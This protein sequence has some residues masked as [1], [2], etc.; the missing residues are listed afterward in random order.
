MRSNIHLV[1]GVHLLQIAFSCLFF[2]HFSIGVVIFFSPIC[3]SGFLLFFLNKVYNDFL[4]SHGI[5]MF[6]PFI[7]CIL[8]YLLNFDLEEF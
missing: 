3:K 5:A 1:S 7:T 2:Y 8:I 6:S 4:S